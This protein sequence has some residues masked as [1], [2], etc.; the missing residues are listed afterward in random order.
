MQEDYGMAGVRCWMSW[1]ALIVATLIVRPHR[2]GLAMVGVL[3]L[4]WAA[5]SIRF[6]IRSVKAGADLLDIDVMLCVVALGLTVTGPLIMAPVWL[7]MRRP[8]LV[9]MFICCLL[10]GLARLTFRR[11]RV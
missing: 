1:L 8:E 7:H 11:R 3:T 4:V 10:G 6:V 5:Y 9:V 2:I